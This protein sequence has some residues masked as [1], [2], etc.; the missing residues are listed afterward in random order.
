MIDNTKIHIKINKTTDY[1]C[2]M[3]ILHIYY[4]YYRG[5][6]HVSDILF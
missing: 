4:V 6:T 1:Q 2:F 3:F 5:V